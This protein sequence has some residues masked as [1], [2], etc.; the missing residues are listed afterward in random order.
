MATPEEIAAQQAAMARAFQPSAQDI[1][2]MPAAQAQAL[3]QR[4]DR[5]KREMDDFAAQALRMMQEPLAAEEERIAAKY[6]PM[7]EQ[8]MEQGLDAESIRLQ[9][10]A[11][12]AA[13][14]QSLQK[15]ATDQLDAMRAERGLPTI[16]Q[17]EQERAIIEP[18]LGTAIAVTR[19]VEAG[20]SIRPS[21]SAMEADAPR[22]L[23]QEAKFEA[24]R[25]RKIAEEMIEAE[26]DP[27]KMDE[28]L[29]KLSRVPQGNQN[30]TI[31]LLQD[32][33]F[34]P[35]RPVKLQGGGSVDF[36]QETP[37]G[38]GYFRMPDG[39]YRVQLPDGTS[40]TAGSEF[41]AKEMMGS[42]ID[43]DAMGSAKSPESIQ[44][45]RKNFFESNS[46]TLEAMDERVRNA[47]A[48]GVT[49]PEGGTDYGDPTL[50]DPVGGTPGGG[51]GGG[52]GAPDMGLPKLDYLL[53]MGK[54]NFKNWL[55][56][57]IT[58]RRKTADERAAIESDV[59]GKASTLGLME[60]IPGLSKIPAAV[61]VAT[62]VADTLFP[63]NTTTAD[64]IIQYRRD[65][66]LDL[67]PEIEQSIR[68]RQA[69]LR[70]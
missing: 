15:R 36:N 53:E 55:E 35:P 61:N 7:I 29:D 31:K 8:A 44:K 65:K 49:L 70:Q 16:S 22:I 54:S 28:F 67:T 51:A 37:T 12:L 18:D 30:K 50:G 34:S 64:E 9:Q 33:G 27:E 43:V 17:I 69:Q 32:L 41:E 11:E 42:V 20:N 57:M 52:S 6:A 59:A 38:G 47:F 58:G 19:E 46:Q 25:D 66:G 48:G 45:A 23:A 39:T 14:T 5:L 2:N 68:N 13:V 26:Q 56:S 40:A 60:D 21:R 3:L 62:S 63:K 24:Q 10:E 1:S 4:H